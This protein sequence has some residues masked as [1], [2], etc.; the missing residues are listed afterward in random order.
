M[1]CCRTWCGYTVEDCEEAGGKKRVQGDPRG[2]GGPPHMVMRI[3][4]KL[5]LGAWLVVGAAWGAP[6]YRLVLP[7]G[8]PQP[9]IP[10][11]NPLTAEKVRLGRHLFYDKRR[12]GNGKNS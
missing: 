11:D 12:S 5:A 4:R 6:A 2:P 9:R 10:A 8:F 7:K 3:V 1:A